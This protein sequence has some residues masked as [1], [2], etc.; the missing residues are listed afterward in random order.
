MTNIIPFKI[1]GTPM[2]NQPAATEPETVQRLPYSFDI[3]QVGDNVMIDAC[4]PSLVA[5]KIAQLI[6]EHAEAAD[7]AP[8]AGKRR[9]RKA[10]A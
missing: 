10:V 7:A 3:I 4:V 5:V 2:T 6:L 8:K 1:P 9:S